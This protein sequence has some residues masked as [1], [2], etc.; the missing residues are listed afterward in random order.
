MKQEI[1]LACVLMYMSL[2][3]CSYITAGMCV[4]SLLCAPALPAG[5]VLVRKRFESRL[6]E[7]RQLIKAECIRPGLHWMLLGRGDAP[8]RMEPSGAVQWQSAGIGP[9][10][11]TGIVKEIG[12]PFAYSIGS[13][14]FQHSAGG[15]IDF[16]LHPR[17]NFGGIVQWPVESTHNGV[18]IESSDTVHR[19]GAWMQFA[20]GESLR[21]TP[22]VFES[23]LPGIGEDDI[24]VQP[25][26]TRYPARSERRR[27]RTFAVE[28]QM[29]ERG[30]KC[31]L[32]TA[33]ISSPAAAPSL[34][35]RGYLQFGGEAKRD[36]G[37]R[38]ED[39]FQWQYSLLGRWIGDHFTTAGGELPEERASLAAMLRAG[40]GGNELSVKAAL[41]RDK[42]P[43]VPDRYIACDREIGG[44][45]CWAV[46]GLSGRAEA[47]HSWAF[48]EEGQLSGRYKYTAEIGLKRNVWEAAACTSCTVPH[49]APIEWRQK[50]TCEAELGQWQLRGALSLEEQLS[51]W[52]GYL[53]CEYNRSEL[54]L[55]MKLAFALSRESPL[56]TP[57]SLGVKLEHSEVQ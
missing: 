28:L 11:L 18:F 40:C 46:A 1:L 4:L 52:E 19:I 17:K 15:R 39:S 55:W 27:S 33:L 30:C 37:G 54:C 9:V 35:G 41:I 53:R 8:L 43:P 32:L 24:E 56:E 20:C 48:D 21:I 57:L 38:R 47:V 14:V 5:K 12:K 44:K 29:E 25:L 42:Q 31:S 22:C 2:L 50:F 34:F 10:I 36:T 51:E 7:N 13:A 49:I 16:S 26:Q 6:E 23:L 45:L 3:K